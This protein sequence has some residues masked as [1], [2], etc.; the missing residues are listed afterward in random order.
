M[1]LNISKLYTASDQSG[2]I[3]WSIAKRPKIGEEECGDDFLI[4]ICK[5]GVLIAVVDGLGHGKNAATASRKAI[6]SLKNFNSD[7]P[8][9]LVKDCHQNLKNTRG[10]VVSLAYIDCKEETI[11]WIGIGNVHGVLLKK[12]VSYQHKENLYLRGGVVGYTLPVLQS[13]MLPIVHGDTLVFHTDGVKRFYSDEI[14][15]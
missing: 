13:A 7:N 2:C 11:N 3:D 6:D 14:S 8:I 9:S 12:G 4:K 10:A 5:T 15:T 1:N